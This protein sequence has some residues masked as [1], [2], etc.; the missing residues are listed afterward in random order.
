MFF[1]RA[2]LAGGGEA[3]GV[4]ASCLTTRTRKDHYRI[5]QRWEQRPY[6]ETGAS[7]QP[8]V[9]VAAVREVDPLPGKK[10]SVSGLRPAHQQEEE[11]MTRPNLHQL[12]MTRSWDDRR[13][14][15]RP[16]CSLTLCLSANYGGLFSGK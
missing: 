7:S 6:V 11:A 10:V 14:A 2:D 4:P 8:R 3:C 15:V 9:R 13:D 12:V 1:V 5:R 16:S